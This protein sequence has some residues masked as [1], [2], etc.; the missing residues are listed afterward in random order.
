[1]IFGFNSA[2]DHSSGH[3]SFFSRP[4]GSEAEVPA[5]RAQLSNHPDHVGGFQ[6]AMPIF[7]GIESKFGLVL[8]KFT[9]AT[10]PGMVTNAKLLVFL[11]VC[12]D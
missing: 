3:L 5:G 1:M 6:V 2:S 11:L 10:V 12:S 9:H 4:S 8:P 7:S